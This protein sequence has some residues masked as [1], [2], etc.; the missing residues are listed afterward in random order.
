MIDF[1]QHTT[2]NTPTKRKCCPDLSLFPASNWHCPPRHSCKA[3][4]SPMNKRSDC[5]PPPPSSTTPHSEPTTSLST[6]HIDISQPS[7]NTTNTVKLSQK[8]IDKTKYQIQNTKQN[9][10]G[11]IQRAT[12]IFIHNIPQPPHT[13]PP[14][15]HLSECSSPTKLIAHTTP[16]QH[17]VPPKERDK[18]KK[19]SPHTTKPPTG[20]HIA[21]SAA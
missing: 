4:F 12:T 21:K 13:H 5:T 20:C 10:K 11:H 7:T 15:S 18:Q 6:H 2:L 19:P 17:A 1:E 14:T 8:P 3:P 16:H 9:K